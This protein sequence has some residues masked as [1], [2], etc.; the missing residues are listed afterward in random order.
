[1]HTVRIAVPVDRG[2]EDAEVFEH[3]G[4]APYYMIV[5][6]KNN[7][8]SKIEYIKNPFVEHSPGEIPR[9]LREHNVSIVICMGIGRRARLFFSEYGIEVISG[10]MGR[11]IE[12]VEKYLRGELRSIEYRPKTRWHH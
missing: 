12:C 8:I 7:K 9:M 3:F 4:R 6:V 1:M 5:E 11:A 10:A 2:S